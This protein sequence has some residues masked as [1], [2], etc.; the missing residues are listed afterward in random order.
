MRV[1]RLLLLLVLAAPSV[2]SAEDAERRADR[3]RTQQ[4]NER[5]HAVVAKRDRLNAGNRDAYRDARKDYE[6]EMAEWRRRVTDCRAGD[7]GACDKR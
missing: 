4:L 6:R 2:A 5:A 3:L 7:W 1:R